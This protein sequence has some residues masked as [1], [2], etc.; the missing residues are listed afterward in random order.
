MKMR[1][2]SLTSRDLGAGDIPLYLLKHFG[3]VPWNLIIPS[4]DQWSFS[5][6]TEPL[7]WG[8][9]SG[10]A[11]WAQPSL[12]NSAFG[13]PSLDRT[14]FLSYYFGKHWGMGF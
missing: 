9:G 8:W 4:G 6:G 1:N 14:P 3:Y 12:W 7:R 11:Y 5:Y 10:V 13:T 2:L